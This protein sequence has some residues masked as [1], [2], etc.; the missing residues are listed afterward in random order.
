MRS[1]RDA[2]ISSSTSR[3]NNVEQVKSNANYGS[4]IL[5]INPYD[6]FPSGITLEEYALAMDEEFVNVAPPILDILI[7]NTESVDSGYDFTLNVTVENS[8]DISAHNV[9]TN[10]TLPSG[11]IIISGANP[12]SMGSIS[13]GDSKNVS[14][15]VKAPETSLNT[16][17][18]I[19]VS[20]T[21]NSYDELY[22]NNSNNTIMVVADS[23]P[24]VSV[25]ALMNVSYASNY[26]NWTWIN[27]QDEDFAK[28]KIYINDVYQEDVLRTEQYYN[29]TDLVYGTY[30][31][32]TRTVDNIGNINATMSTHTAS[33]KLPI[34]RFINGTVMDS[35][36]KTGIAGVVVSANKS[37]STT[38]NASGFYSFTVISGL[39]N[40]SATYDPWYYSNSSMVT[41]ESIAVVI[42]DI[43]LLKKPTGNI[44][45]SV[46]T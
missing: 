24:P 25:D 36:N 38:T 46:S 14:W 7:S 41:T 4:V 28:V 18:N 10:I 22:S 40:I 11:F 8:G 26:I 37:I 19:E 21:S 27:P 6:A 33:T 12:R 42:Q 31:I 5:K 1:A 39:Y 16:Q 3:L 44:T 30:T 34:I 15:V 9:N 23:T 35:V 32:G 20:T 29:A 2:A 43:E 13:S 17:Y 45:G